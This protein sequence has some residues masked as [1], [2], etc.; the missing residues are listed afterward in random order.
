MSVILLSC[1]LSP[2]SK[3]SLRAPAC[4]PGASIGGRRSFGPRSTLAIFPVD[5][6][7]PRRLVRPPRRPAGP[8]PGHGR[9]RGGGRNFPHPLHDQ[10]R[11]L[12]RVPVAAG[13]PRGGHGPDRDPTRRGRGRSGD[14]GLGRGRTRPPWNNRGHPAEGLRLHKPWGEVDGRID[15][16][17]FGAHAYGVRRRRDDVG[18]D[19]PARWG[20]ARARRWTATVGHP[21]ASRGGA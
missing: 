9:A 18:V 21:I 5:D 6:G 10:A 16:E 19:V 13:A 2:V 15:F 3:P 11:D 17:A 7:R 12:R 20:D 14:G 8:G 4:R 1:R